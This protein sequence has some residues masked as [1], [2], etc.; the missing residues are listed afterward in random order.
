M[1]TEVTAASKRARAS[2]TEERVAMIQT[3]LYREA[4][5]AVPAHLCH[6]K[7]AMEAHMHVAGSLCVVEDVSCEGVPEAAAPMAVQYMKQELMCSA[8]ET[9]SFGPE[10]LKELCVG[11]RPDNVVV[12]DDTTLLWFASNKSDELV[13]FNIVN[14]FA[15]PGMLVREFPSLSPRAVSTV[16]S[17]TAVLGT[18]SDAI[19]DLRATL[20]DAEYAAI[21]GKMHAVYDAFSTI[22]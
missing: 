13:V 17:R 22:H 5:D 11:R 9:G 14:W 20:S 12:Y 1:A 6:K 16:A 4:R 18:L 7:Y 3:C 15:F 10:L 19:F 8:L 2:P 21:C